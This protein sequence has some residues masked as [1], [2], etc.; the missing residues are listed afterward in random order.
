MEMA[1]GFGNGN[2]VDLLGGQVVRGAV[3]EGLDGLVADGA[4]DGPNDLRI[5]LG[6]ASAE[7][8]LLSRWVRIFSIATG[9]SMQ[10]MILTAPAHSRQVSMS[11]LNS[12]FR[13]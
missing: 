10:A 1:S 9:S 4:P 13:R 3:G 11:M 8:T 7:A 2:D 5:I 12:R 6:D